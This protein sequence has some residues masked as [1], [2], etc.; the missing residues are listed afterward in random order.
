[1]SHHK[2]IILMTKRNAFPRVTDVESTKSREVIQ[3]H[4]TQV[5]KNIL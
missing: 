2:K 1:M 4:Y 5:C 3:F